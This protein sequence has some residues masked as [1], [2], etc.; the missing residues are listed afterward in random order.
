LEG[1][2]PT[3]KTLVL[4][5]ASQLKCQSSQKVR[6]IWMKRT[7]SS[8]SPG[9]AGGQKE[10]IQFQLPANAVIDMFGRLFG[11]ILAT[12]FEGKLDGFGS[13]EATGKHL[14]DI[15]SDFLHQFREPDSPPPCEREPVVEVEDDCETNVLDRELW[16]LQSRLSAASESGKPTYGRTVGLIARSTPFFDREGL[17]EYQILPFPERDVFEGLIAFLTRRYQGNPHDKG[18]VVADATPYNEQAYNQPRNALDLDNISSYFFSKNAKDQ[19][20]S[21]DFKEMRVAVTHYILR[22]PDGRAFLRSWVLEGSENKVDW[23]ELDCRKDDQG[24]KGKDLVCRYQVRS[25]IE[26]RFIRLRST[27]LDWCGENYLYFKAIELFG[28]LRVPV[29]TNLTRA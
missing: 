15:F 12:L 7:S 23:V 24:L 13:R 6:S 2:S 10:E 18:I 8:S 20:M 4:L 16:D 25:V 9:V 11:T 27:G 5:D 26:S 17:F 29:P 14:G 28:G 19:W 3:S 22:S 21:V 1:Q